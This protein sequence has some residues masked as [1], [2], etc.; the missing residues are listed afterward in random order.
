VC[1]KGGFSG[2]RKQDRARRFAVHADNPITIGQLCG[3]EARSR[4]RHIRQE[5][6]YLPP[7]SS[8]K[9]PH[10]FNRIAFIV[11]PSM[12]NGMLARRYDP[13]QEHA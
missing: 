6:V 7:I 13:K 11:R 10:S 9:R 4:V 2:E 8:T 5:P 1:E 12:N 3:G